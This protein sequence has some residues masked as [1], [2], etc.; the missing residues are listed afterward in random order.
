[1]QTD[2]LGGFLWG[3]SQSFARFFGLNVFAFFAPQ[4]TLKQLFL[5]WHKKYEQERLVSQGKAS[6]RYCPHLRSGIKKLSTV[7]KF[8]NLR[9]HFNGT[10]LKV[11]GV[12]LLLIYGPETQDKG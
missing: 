4:Q 7:I 6:E 8:S 3:S 2:V 11:L 12:V 5:G 9:H 1:M 10:L